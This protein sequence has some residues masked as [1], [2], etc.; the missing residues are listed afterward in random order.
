VVSDDIVTR[1]REALRHEDGYQMTMAPELVSAIADEI[2]RLRA[3]ADDLM[4]AAEVDRKNLMLR[5][6]AL[7]LAYRNE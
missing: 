7:E 4:E 5:I 3:F 6:L 1:L 2:E